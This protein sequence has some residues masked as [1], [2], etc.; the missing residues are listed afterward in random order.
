MN[1]IKT[2]NPDGLKAQQLKKHKALATGLFLLMAVIYILCIWMSKNY[3]FAWIGFVKAFSE[4]AMVGALADWFAVTALFHHPLGIPIPHTNLIETRKKD[5]GDNLGGFVV[6]NFMNAATI[7][8]YIQKLQVSNYVAQW[9]DTEKNTDLLL[10]EIVWLLKDIIHKIDDTTVSKFLAH[11]SK[12]ILNDL[13]L[14]E[15]LAGGLNLIIERGDHDRILNYILKNVHDYVVNNEEL[16][17]RKV[18]EESYFLIPGFVDNIIASKLTKGVARYLSEIE[19]DPQHKL[20]TDLKGQMQ[21][22][23]ENVKTD[24]RWQRELQE[25]KNN[26]LAGGKMNQYA[27]SAWKSLQASALS[28]LSAERSAVKLYLKKTVKEM[29]QNLKND[30]PLRNKIDGWIRFNAYKYILKNSNRVGEL[31]SN[32]VGD[33][34]GKELSNKLE[35]EVGK[36]LQFIRINGTLVGGLVGLIIYTITKLIEN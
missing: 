14:N 4:A 24:E 32:T 5:I 7:R 21:Q 6:S 34:E 19:A 2:Q 18:K 25:I 29:V 16:V 17:R 33:W 22:F 11:K 35:L 8:P 15:A 30:E 26:L 20:R 28:D 3:D 1:N 36:D 9:L 10:N 31:I 23:I 13:K 27:S 12:D